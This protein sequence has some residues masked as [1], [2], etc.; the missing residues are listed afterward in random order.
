M[1]YSVINRLV[2][3]PPAPGNRISFVSMR[4]TD[5]LD[6]GELH[7]RA[8]RLALW[9]RA[10]GLAPGDRIG[11]QAPNCL[12]WVLLDLAALRLKVVTAGF[13]PG[14]F[15]PSSAFLD[16]YRLK[17]FFTDGPW[18]DP[19]VLAI[20]DVPDIAGKAVGAGR[21]PP[22]A[23]PVE[24]VTTLKF[25][26]G[27]TGQPKGL[28][29]TAG[30]IDS[31]LR[32]VQ[33]MFSH[34]PGDDLFVFLPLSLL[35]QRYW[36]YSAL[37]FGHD[38]TVSTYEAAFAALGRARPTVVMG[39]PAFFESAKK[40]IETQA[41]SAPPGDGADDPLP[42]AARRFFGDRIR[43]L[44][45]GSAPA[46]PAMLRFFNSVGL[47]IYEGYGLNETC[48]V[49]KNHPAANKVGSV[50]RVLPEKQV[51][52]GRNGV[53]SV[54]CHY[55]VNRRYEYAAPG[56][57]ERLFGPD[58]VVRTGDLGHIDEDGF[59]YIRGRADDLIVLTNGRK[60]MVRPI[61]EHM[62]ES[63]AIDECV[64]VS[65]ARTHLVAVVSP[66]REPAD[67]E[68]IARQLKRTNSVFG[69]EA[70]ISRVVVASDRFSIANGLLTS[71]FKPIRA[72]IEEA[73]RSEI[74]NAERGIH[75]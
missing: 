30:S 62:R 73:Y 19:R 53:I 2:T 29:A 17:R 35:Q 65:P 7:E 5:S 28:G 21:L 9:M 16:R 34:G 43:Y 20:A 22:I 61:E 31:S 63:P 60:V 11:I 72:R 3:S 8:E 32:A 6:L 58:G 10:V 41:T 59:L 69:A 56:E 54:R 68:A 4:G 18:D 55:P 51:V 44:W 45:T 70:R 75:A 66:T 23:Y 37:C 46:S 74:Q 39:V 13:E 12:G 71:Q 24:D 67:E 27:S 33:Q 40:H 36:I 15:D 38:V 50:G 64:L 26:S 52:L 25:T 42:G 49:S 47:P 14:R 48:I 1:T 57:S